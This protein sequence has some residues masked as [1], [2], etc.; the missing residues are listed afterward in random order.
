[1][2]WDDVSP[3]VEGPPAPTGSLLTAEGS[4]SR[5]IKGSNNTSNYLVRERSQ[6]DY[7]PRALST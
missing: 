3:E 7:L 4:L 2:S 1:M 6:W 5:S